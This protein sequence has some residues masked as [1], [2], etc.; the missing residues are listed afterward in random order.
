MATGTYTNATQ[1]S[2]TD[3]LERGQVAP[4][5]PATRY[6]GIIVAT[7]GLSG[8]IRS[9]AVALNDTVI[10]Q[11]PNGYIY[12]CTTA[13]TTGASE[14]TWPTTAAGTVTDGTAVWTEQSTAMR[15]GTF[16]EASYTGYAR[17]AV[18]PSLTSMAGT[19]GAGTTLASS[20]TSGQT[21]NNAAITFGAPSTANG[22]AFGWFR[23]TALTAGTIWDFGADTTPLAISAGGSAPQYAISAFA[24]IP[25]N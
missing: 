15:A 5:P 23:S 6:Y 14:P 8:G 25:A 20:G 24:I 4:T 11:T 12:K 19:Q 22:Y 21:S 10:P 3:W 17:V 1:N 2:I 9:A 18:T 7:R 16:T 13:G